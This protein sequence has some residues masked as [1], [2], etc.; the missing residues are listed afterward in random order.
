MREISM[1]IF[2][3]LGVTAALVAC[4]GATTGQDLTG[5]TQS[6]ATIASGSS[7]S[8]NDTDGGARKHRGHHRD[9]DG[10]RD[11]DH[12]GDGDPDGDHDGRGGACDHGGA[13]PPASAAS[14]PVPDNGGVK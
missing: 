12:D 2:I 13:S 14:A 4:S 9:H 7:E 3:P 5:S 11:R 1:G 10:D 8:A 6:A